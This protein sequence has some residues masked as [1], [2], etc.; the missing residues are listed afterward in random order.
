MKLV[1][2]HN[3]AKQAI[4]NH[5]RATINLFAYE[6]IQ[7]VECGHHFFSCFFINWA[8]SFLLFVPSKIFPKVILMS[9]GFKLGLP[10]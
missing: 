3:T 5:R 2:L 1:L 6:H 8:N 7:M 4:Y 9:A 10:K